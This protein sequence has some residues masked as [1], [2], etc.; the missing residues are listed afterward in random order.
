[1]D[2]ISFKIANDARRK[3]EEVQA[4]MTFIQTKLK[5]W[6][7]YKGKIDGLWGHATESAVRAFQKAMGLKVDGAVGPATLKELNRPQVV[8]FKNY[9]FRCKCGKCSGLPSKGVDIEFKCMLEEVRRRNGNKP[10]IIRSGYRCPAHN[11][12]VGGAAKSQH[13]SNPVWAADIFSPG[14]S[15]RV[16]EKICDDVF[17]NHGVGLG[18][19]NIVHVDRRPG[20]ARWKYN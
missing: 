17:K 18:G 13:M 14:T 15:P 2:I 8:N 16:L 7:F 10:I 1:M 3:W 5:E 11:R 20:R 9:E 4:Q 19:R 6:G 12:A